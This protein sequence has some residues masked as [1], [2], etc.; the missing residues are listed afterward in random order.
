MIVPAYQVGQVDV[1]CQ[2]QELLKGVL[3]EV[4]TDELLVELLLI[5]LELLILQ[6]R[7]CTAEVTAAL[8]EGCP[9]SSSEAASEA[10][11]L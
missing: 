1:L 6:L 8:T 4:A 9:I 2:G 7:R 11:N 3:R 5:D 10:D